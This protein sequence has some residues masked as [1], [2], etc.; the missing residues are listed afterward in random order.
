[1]K[2]FCLK[3]IEKENL[4]LFHMQKNWFSNGRNLNTLLLSRANI[5]YLDARI[6]S[7]KWSI[8]SKNMNNFFIHLTYDCGESRWHTHT[9]SL[10]KFIINST[11]TSLR[12]RAIIMRTKKQFEWFQRRWRNKLCIQSTIQFDINSI[13]LHPLPH[14]QSDN[15]FVWVCTQISSMCESWASVCVCARLF[16]TDQKRLTQPQHPCDSQLNSIET[17]QTTQCILNQQTWLLLLF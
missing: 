9:A 3:F 4:W 1:M 17:I 14:M 15:W 5:I 2:Y 10:Y 13:S 6:C 12:C 8:R 11:W 16:F 7:N